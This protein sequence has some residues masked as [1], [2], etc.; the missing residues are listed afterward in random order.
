MEK[1]QHIKLFV[2]I[3]ITFSLCLSLSI[4]FVDELL[5]ENEAQKVALHNAIK[6]SK[7]REGVFQTYLHKTEDEMLAIKS[8][9]FFNQYLYAGLKRPALEDLFYTYANSN[10]FISSIRFIDRDGQERI[11]VARF[12]K[13]PDRLDVKNPSK[14]YK[15]SQYELKNRSAMPYFIE[16]KI[17]PKNEV[18]FSPIA[19]NAKES[20]SQFVYAPTM[21]MVLPIKY[22]N[23][24]AGVFIV[25]HMMGA[26]LKDLTNT[27]LYD[28]I[29][30]N[31][32]GNILYHYLQKGC[33]NSRC[34]AT[35]LGQN[36]NIADDF[37]QYAQQILHTPLLTTDK[38]VSAKLD[39]PIEGGMNI[40]FQLN[41]AYLKQQQQQ[42]YK[43]Y[44][45]TTV[46]IFLLS[47]VLT[48]VVIKLFSQ[49]L[50]N[51][52]QLSRL[53][54]SLNDA[55]KVA[56]IGFWESNGYVPGK[57]F[58][59]AHEIFEIENRD[60]SL[61]M[62]Q[63]QSFLSDEDF[64]E[65]KRR[66]EYS[67]KQKTEYF[68]T[69]QIVTEK[70]N[71]KYVEVRARHLFD[72]NGKYQKSI[73]SVY[74]VTQRIHTEELLKEEKYKLETIFETVLEGICVLTLETK[75]EYFNKNYLNI[76]ECSEDELR[77]S[78][79]YDWVSEDGRDKAT[80]VFKELFRSGVPQYFE[81][82]YVTRDGTR[83]RLSS[84]VALM[85]DKR[86]ILMTTIDNTRLHN[87][88]QVIKE[89]SI[90]DDLTHLHNRKAYQS[91]VEELLVEYQ[92]YASTFSMMMLD[93]DFFKSVNDVY[94]HPVGDKVL[95]ALSQLIKDRIRQCDFAYRIGGEEFIVL[96]PNT[97]LKA[98]SI[99]AEQLRVSVAEDLRVIEDR[100]ITISI[101][102]VEVNMEDD[103]SSIFKRVDD[104]LYVAKRSG[105]NRVSV[106]SKP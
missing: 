42:T 7:E 76:I 16:S 85:S 18:W 5:F 35:V 98:A 77:E 1:K 29:L 34:I 25:S 61:S 47:I 101:G 12:P 86:Q 79:F 56:K 74:D 20:R 89:Q 39:L 27:P 62:Q 33:E 6:K 67:V 87:A 13:Q 70:N 50:T 46:I 28:I 90:T 48:Y 10:P 65:L 102:L 11:K 38:F 43:Q 58:S 44:L 99:L 95:V 36:R 71:I 26:F 53:H 4:M 14:P 105:R 63:F 51:I 49:K 92:R 106:E 103:E 73:G 15:I 93:I 75:Y 60:K 78:N 23:E 84:S 19:L 3:F 45:A 30:F 72:N 22:R 100:R 21:D 40:A 94:G 9:F 32:K 57:W 104:H 64:A 17:K 2:Y 81:R 54:E 91:K 96:L 82:D 8:S 52:E 88:M 37:P 68:F 83:K 80:A 31:D 59:G 24:F 97:E 55:S 69:H 66:F 41:K